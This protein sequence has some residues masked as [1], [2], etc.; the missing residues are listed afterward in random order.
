MV[1]VP[2]PVKAIL[3]GYKEKEHE[4]MIKLQK[5]LKLPKL[6]GSELPA[7]VKEADSIALATE[8]VQLLNGSVEDWPVFKTHKPIDFKIDAMTPEESKKAFLIYWRKLQKELKS[9]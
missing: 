8:A 5:A 1:D 4:V 3:S 2:T 7:I 9:K 6:K